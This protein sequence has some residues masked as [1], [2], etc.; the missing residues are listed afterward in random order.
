MAISWEA[1]F[2]VLDKAASYVLG[3]RVAKSLVKCNASVVYTET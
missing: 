3:L 2:R 1:R